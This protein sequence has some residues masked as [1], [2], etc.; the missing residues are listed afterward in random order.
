MTQNTR[1]DNERLYGELIAAAESR[2]PA[3]EM[4]ALISQAFNAGWETGDIFEALSE[5]GL[6]LSFGVIEGLAQRAIIR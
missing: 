3:T 5:G 1:I 6:E 2:L 4:G